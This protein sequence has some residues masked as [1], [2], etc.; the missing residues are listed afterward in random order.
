[1]SLAGAE[2]SLARFGRATSA[3]LLLQVSCNESHSGVVSINVGVSQGMETSVGGELVAPTWSEEDMIGGLASS[4]SSL[5]RD[6]TTEDASS[7][8]KSSS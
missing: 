3:L 4:E 6:D 1:M 5:E 8:G 2:T 7:R